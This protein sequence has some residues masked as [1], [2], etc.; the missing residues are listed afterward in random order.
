MKIII[1][2]LLLVSIAGADPIVNR[3][4]S[5]RSYA[6]RAV[7]LPDAGTALLTTAMGTHFINM[8][9]SKV[10]HDFPAVSAIDTAILYSTI[11][12]AVL[13]DT[14]LY[15]RAVF[16]M[17][18]DSIRYPLKRMDIDSFTAKG[19]TEEEVKH[20]INSLSSPGYYYIFNNKLM[21]HPKYNKP[22][23]KL[24]SFLVLYQATGSPLDK[25]TDTTDCSPL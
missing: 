3:L 10:C 19:A 8:A 2:L 6:F 12:G 17:R 15:D 23:A 13:P 16:R 11:E 18:G 25:I 9:Y 4:D 14:F 22:I 5:L 21:T 24:D 20:V 7:N 1:I